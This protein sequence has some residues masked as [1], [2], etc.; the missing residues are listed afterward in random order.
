[1]TT[2]AFMSGERWR[3]VGRPRRKNRAPGQASTSVVSANWIRFDPVMPMVEAI[4]WWKPG[5][6]CAPM[7]ST[8]TGSDSAAAR[9]VSRFSAAPS[10]ACRASA[11]SAAEAPVVASRA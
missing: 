4:R 3:S 1:M 8:T 11:C 9:S 5:T 6:R 10:A 7:A 2:S